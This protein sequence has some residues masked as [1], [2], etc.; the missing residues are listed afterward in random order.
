MIVVQNSNNVMVSK[1]IEA[2]TKLVVKCWSDFEIVN[3]FEI[4]L[5]CISLD[6]IVGKG[7]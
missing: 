7:W 3:H 5:S 4:R 2:C 1:L 6:V